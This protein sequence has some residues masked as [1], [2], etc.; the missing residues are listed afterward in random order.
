MAFKF[1]PS[2]TLLSEALCF[3]GLLNRS[4]IAEW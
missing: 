2:T 4:K 1:Y 3:K